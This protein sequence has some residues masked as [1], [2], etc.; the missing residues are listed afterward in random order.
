[1]AFISGQ[2][3]LSLTLSLCI[4]VLLSQVTVSLGNDPIGH[5]K[6]LG[7]HRPSE[8]T[9]D[10]LDGF[11]DP[12]VFFQDYVHASKPVLFKNAARGIPAFNLW[13]DQ[14]LK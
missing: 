11:P 5:L 9:V 7:S 1:M 10:V 4:V 14:Y 3:T 2:S 13:T 6:P 8:G 12:H